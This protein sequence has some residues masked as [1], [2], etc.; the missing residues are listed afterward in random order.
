MKAQEQALAATPRKAK[1]DK[2][3][4][5]TLAKEVDPEVSIHDRDPN[6]VALNDVILNRLDELV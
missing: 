3:I 4:E 2:A 1:I 5:D 6:V